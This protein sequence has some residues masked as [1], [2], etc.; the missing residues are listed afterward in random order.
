MQRECW[1][2]PGASWV[3][4]L[5]TTLICSNDNNNNINKV[6]LHWSRQTFLTL[7]MLPTVRQTFPRVCRPDRFTFRFRFISVI[8]CCAY[9][10]AKGKRNCSYAVWKW[11][12]TCTSQLQNIANHV[13]SHKQCHSCSLPETRKKALASF[14]AASQTFTCYFLIFGLELIWTTSL[15]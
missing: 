6:T 1:W 12:S 5:T 4:S 8:W 13:S 10:L 9:N 14:K 2:R 11:V 7:F 15:C 3:F